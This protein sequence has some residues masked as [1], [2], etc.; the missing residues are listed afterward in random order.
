MVPNVN[1][2]CVVEILSF[3]VCFKHG[4]PKFLDLPQSSD[5]VGGWPIRALRLLLKVS[6]P[7]WAEVH[8]C[9]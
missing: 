6:I 4:L 2:K 3:S 9:Y 7:T 5:T 1:L 8:P